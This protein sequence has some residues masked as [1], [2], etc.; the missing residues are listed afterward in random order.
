MISPLWFV[1]HIDLERSGSL[2]C[3]RTGVRSRT[4]DKSFVFTLCEAWSPTTRRIPGLIGSSSSEFFCI[5]Y[6][7]CDNL[8]CL[9]DVEI[10]PPKDAKIQI[11]WSSKYARTCGLLYDRGLTLLRSVRPI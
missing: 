1:Y 11:L 9:D 2:S 4:G 3:L 6:V 5:A 7:M 10:N 8:F